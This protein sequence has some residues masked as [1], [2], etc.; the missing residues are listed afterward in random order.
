MSNYGFLR[1]E[2]SH[3]IGSIIFVYTQVFVPRPY[4]MQIWLVISKWLLWQNTDIT[5]ISYLL[6]LHHPPQ[7][8]YRGEAYVWRAV[9]TRVQKLLKVKQARDVIINLVL[10][11]H[12]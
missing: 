5:C 1:A 4:S 10:D 12:S 3:I 6:R 8:T 7:D 2:P 9:S 11:N